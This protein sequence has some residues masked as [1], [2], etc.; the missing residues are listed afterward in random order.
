MTA[1][2]NRQLRPGDKIIV[3]VDCGRFSVETTFTICEIKYQEPYEW[4]NAYY[5][6]FI[7]ENGRF[8][9]WQQLYDGGRAVL[10]GEV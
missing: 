9:Q 2:T 8:H 3:P 5:V 4:R 7:D 6:D 1:T 10:I